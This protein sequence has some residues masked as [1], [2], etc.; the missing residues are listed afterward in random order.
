MDLTTTE[1]QPI[2]PEPSARN[3]PVI[4]TADEEQPLLWF[5]GPG[6][7]IAERSVAGAM[8]ERHG[9]YNRDVI[10]EESAAR[11]KRGE[12]ALEYGTPGRVPIYEYG[13]LVGHEDT[14]SPVLGSKGQIIGYSDP[15]TVEITAELILSAGHEPQHEDM[16]RW[17]DISAA[18][19]DR[20]VHDKQV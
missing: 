11:V 12:S 14:R 9:I 18:D 2:A 17:A 8:V 3:K 16:T 10:L 1:E 4:L 7:T 6:Q 15:E 5:Y 19:S 13:E 20:C